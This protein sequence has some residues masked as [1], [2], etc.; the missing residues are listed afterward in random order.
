MALIATQTLMENL[1]IRKPKVTRI[2]MLI[3]VFYLTEKEKKKKTNLGKNC[4]K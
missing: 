2:L 4:D 1:T 3:P